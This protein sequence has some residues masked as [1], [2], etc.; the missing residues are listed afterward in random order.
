MRH[1]G[2]I[3]V[4]LLLSLN[5]S[6]NVIVVAVNQSL[7]D[8]PVALL[9]TNLSVGD[10]LFGLQLAVIGLAD[11]V[12]TPPVPPVLCR[13]LQYVVLA[14]SWQVKTAQLL[15]ALDM[16]IA[17]VLP[18]H[19]HQLMADWLRPML[20]LPWVMMLLNIVVGVVCS[21]LQ[22]ESTY[23]Y[24]LTRGWLTEVGADCRWEMLPSVYSFIW[25]GGLFVMSSISGSIFLYAIVVGI[26]QRR[27]IEERDG[28][29]AA[30]SAF[31]LRRFKSL[32][33]IAK[34]VSLFISL[35]II[36]AAMRISARW[37]YM[38]FVSTAIHFLR[39]VFAAAETW[40]YGMNNT[41]LRNAFNSFFGERL[42]FL[43]CPR[44]VRPEVPAVPAIGTPVERRSSLE[45]GGSARRP[46]IIACSWC[47]TG[48][49]QDPAVDTRAAGIE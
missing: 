39:I 27:A 14:T 1:L 16:L 6:A 47:H 12:L 37:Y 48:P 21:T 4:G 25:E 43:R 11:V 33:K 26:R 35:D 40:V 15:V 44:H 5:C 20:I 29:G 41:S 34:V 2:K 22:L 30:D 10:V 3:V 28:A 49:P 18:L 19:Y 32:Q 46:R 31:F 42:G 17:V 8:E 45:G 24:G 13:T 38:P 36:S 9:V 7:W 23:E